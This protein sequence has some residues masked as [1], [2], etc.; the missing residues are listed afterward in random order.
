MCK[1]CS[2]SG[3]LDWKNVRE[4]LK[5]FIHKIKA[6]FEIDRII[7]FG[8]FARGDYHENSDVDLIIVG[9]FQER[10]FDRIG[11]VLQYAPKGI[12]IE[13]FVYNR[14]EFLQMLET[15]NPFIINA[16]SNGIELQ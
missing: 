13:P 8:S 12:E 15:E 11:K 10:F 2:Q 7:L 16:V 14:E 6:N 4:D 3:F 5:E 1:I 9:E